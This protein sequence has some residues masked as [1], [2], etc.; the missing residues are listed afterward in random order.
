MAQ[1]SN[2]T[3]MRI[4]DNDFPAS[5][6]WGANGVD[7]ISVQDI[8]QGYIGN[9]WIMAAVSALAEHPTRVDGLMVSNDEE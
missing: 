3:W 5:T 9:C 2:V 8:N 7:S 6:F 1:I 4:S